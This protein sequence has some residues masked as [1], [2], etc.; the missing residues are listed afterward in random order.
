MF[1][2]FDYKSDEDNIDADDPLIIGWPN[3]RWATAVAKDSYV[4]GDETEILVHYFG[5][6]GKSFVSSWVVKKK[7]TQYLQDPKKTAAPKEILQG[8]GTKRRIHTAPLRALNEQVSWFLLLSCS[9]HVLSSV[10]VL[11][12][13]CSVWFAQSSAGIRRT[14]A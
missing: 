3:R 8:K 12:L 5:Y 6:D 13:Q 14:R 2:A 4:G 9:L 10:H 1:T 7:L 11:A